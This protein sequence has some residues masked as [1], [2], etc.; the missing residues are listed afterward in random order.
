MNG[1]RLF[2]IKVLR[3]LKLGRPGRSVKGKGKGK[4][5]REV[6]PRTCHKC[7]EGEYTYSSTLSSTLTLD[8]GGGV[9]ATPRSLYPRERPGTNRI[10]GWVRPKAVVDGC[11]NFFPHWDSIPV[12]SRP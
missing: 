5:K 3:N 12:P 11:G 10:E 4:G 9:N 8:G 6:H 2:T 1:R 7:T